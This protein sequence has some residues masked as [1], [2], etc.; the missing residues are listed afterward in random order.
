[1]DY[2]I[3]ILDIVNKEKNSIRGL[4]MIYEAP[5]LRHFTAKFEQV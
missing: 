5:V 3:E 4:K 1:M 2:V